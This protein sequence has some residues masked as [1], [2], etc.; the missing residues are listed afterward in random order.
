MFIHS[1][2]FAANVLY[3]WEKEKKCYGTRV[4]EWKGGCLAVKK[5]IDINYIIVVFSGVWWRW[6]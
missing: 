2:P 5:K 3:V 6:K 1:M 4:S